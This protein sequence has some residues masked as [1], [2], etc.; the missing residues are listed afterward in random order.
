MCVTPGADAGG[1][2]TTIA[3]TV[4]DRARTMVRGSMADM[5]DGTGAGTV[6]VMAGAI[7]GRQHSLAE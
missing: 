6:T 5:A 3:V 7:G 4:T 2:Q 1:G